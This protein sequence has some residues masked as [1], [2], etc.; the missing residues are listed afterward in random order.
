MPPTLACMYCLFLEVRG[1]Y[2]CLDV[3]YAVAI[4]VWRVWGQLESAP[5]LSLY[6]LFIPGGEEILFLSGRTICCC[7]SCVACM[8]TT[9]ECPLP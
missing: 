4:V 7:Y 6:V 8:G 9:R 2:S 3:P 1:F 5:C